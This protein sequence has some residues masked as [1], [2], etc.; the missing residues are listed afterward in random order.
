MYELTKILFKGNLKEA[1]DF[2]REE[3]NKSAL[4]NYGDI[5]SDY[6]NLFISLDECMK[7]EEYPDFLGTVKAS[8]S[9][10]LKKAYRNRDRETVEKI[11]EILDIISDFTGE[12]TDDLF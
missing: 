5:F 3:L 10:V 7:P 12:K 11:K 2:I 9:V 6:F 4:E 1:E 8:V